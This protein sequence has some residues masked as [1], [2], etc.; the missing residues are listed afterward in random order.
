[1]AALHFGLLGGRLL[2][3]VHNESRHSS[4]EERFRRPIEEII[5]PK[6]ITITHALDLAEEAR[7]LLPLL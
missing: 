5:T 3:L 1:M 7:L 2:K 6:A 4:L